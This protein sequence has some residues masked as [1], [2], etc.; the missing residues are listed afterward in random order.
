ML[1]LLLL[2]LPFVF[3]CMMG[4]ETGTDAG[5]GEEDSSEKDEEGTEALQAKLTAKEQELEAAKREAQEVRA[6]IFSPD[7]LAYLQYKDS[8]E[9]KER[10]KEAPTEVELPENFESMTE[11]QKFQ[12]LRKEVQG[13]VES[14]VAEI[15]QRVDSASRAQTVGSL[16]DK[17]K[18][19]H[20]DF[21]ELEPAMVRRA[22]E[23]KALGLTP[24]LPEDLYQLVKAP[25]AEAE[26]T[27]VKGELAQ[28][29]SKA[30][31]LF[32]EGPA[33]LTKTFPADSKGIKQ[34]VQESLKAAYA[35]RGRP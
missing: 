11:A 4:E 26:L 17:C 23:Y 1:E 22:N 29:A 16:V 19:D 18:A 35:N 8:G 32:P 24:P 5:K 6:Q 14:A 13:Q 3:L 10:P 28:T 34:A 7:Y 15:S 2:S 31:G 25:K 9:S 12:F 33:G 21:A 30:G 20:A 27:K